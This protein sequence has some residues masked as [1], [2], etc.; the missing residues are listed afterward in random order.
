[1]SSTAVWSPQPKQVEMMKH[2]EDEGFYGGAAGGGKS[3]Y[4]VIEALRQVN[5]P[6]Y[7]ALILRKTFPELQELLE[8]TM[9]YYPKAYPRAKYNGSEH[10]WTFPSGAKIQFGSLHHLKDRFKYQ[11]QQYNFIGFDELTHF[12][13]DEYDFLRSRC[14]SKAPGLKQ[15]IRATGNPGGIGHGWVK[16]YFVRAGEPSKT[17]W[18]SQKIQYPDGRIEK[19]WLSKVFVPSRVY[20]NKILLQNDKKYLARLAFM[21]EANRKAFLDGDWDT[22]AGQVFT[23]FKIGIGQE[24]NTRKG[25]HV[26]NPFEVPKSWSIIRSFDWGYT[27]PYSVGWWAVDHDGRYYRINELYGCTKEPNTGVKHSVRKIAN[28][29]REKEE[30]DLNLKGREIYGVADPAIFSDR[31]S[32]NS[33]IQSDFAKAG[34]FWSKG[35]NNRLFGKMQMHYRLCFDERG[36]PM[37]Y[38]FNTCKDFIRTIPN[39]VYSE[40]S[41]EDVDTTQED[42]IY[43]ET[44]Y[45]VM[46]NIIPPRESAIYTPI[47]YDPLSGQQM[48]NGARIINY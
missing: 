17:I 35:K 1:M 32:G 31:D 19:M 14:R 40:V 26:I 10:V 12:Q 48:Y 24:L 43:D 47:S 36:I 45:A 3:E 6:Q 9:Y 8:K 18:E 42:H 20:D 38:V 2:G 16:K 29:I 34:V 13:W 39:L 7:K 21:D 4:L 22:F 44:R 15:Y 11:G 25:T 28:L 23:E 41:V 46:E 30:T 33:S 5:H 27:K 37:M